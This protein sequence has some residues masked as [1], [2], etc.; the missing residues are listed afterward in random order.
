MNAVFEFGNRQEG[1]ILAND[2][3]GFLERTNVVE[4]HEST[5][6]TMSKEWAVWL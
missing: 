5:P 2:D 4:V 1:E 3:L 6:L